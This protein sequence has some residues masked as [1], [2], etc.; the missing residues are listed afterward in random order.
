MRHPDGDAVETVAAELDRRGLSAAA[1]LMLDAHRPYRPLASH[2]GTF[3]A[4][5]LRPLLGGCSGSVERL[6]ESD[7]AVD[8]LVARLREVHE[9]DRARA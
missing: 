5:L 7:E 1:L 8:Q 2:L 9:Q 6:L 4:P 3:L